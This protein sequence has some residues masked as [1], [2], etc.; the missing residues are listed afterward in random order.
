MTEQDLYWLA[1][2]MDT[3]LSL[4][5]VTIRG[6]LYPSIGSGS[7]PTAKACAQLCGG[8]PT[9]WY[10]SGVVAKQIVAQIRP[11]L[12]IQTEFA[13]KVLAWQPNAFRKQRRKSP[14]GIRVPRMSPS[15]ASLAAMLVAANAGEFYQV[16][17]RT[18]STSPA[19]E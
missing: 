17:A 15:G 6:R 7:A 3:S 18:T 16:T 2:A 19:V 10:V 4:R 12:R 8:S 13:D 5:F 1:G 14:K 11:L 9:R